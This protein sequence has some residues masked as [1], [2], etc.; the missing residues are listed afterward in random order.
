VPVSVSVLSHK[1]RRLGAF[2]REVLMSKAPRMV[3]ASALVD[4]D[5]VEAF[6]G[7]AKALNRSLPEMLGTA[8]E[9]YALDKLGW[10]PPPETRAYHH[11]QAAAWM[12]QRQAAK[13]R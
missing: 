11:Q 13:R 7:A 4:A 9:N 10:T 5:V 6:K 2:L 3:Y 12:Q 1:E 8:L